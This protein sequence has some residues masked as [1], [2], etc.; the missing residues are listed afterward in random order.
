MP[1][2]ETLT[3]A[4]PAS[5]PGVVV[6]TNPATGEVV[7]QLPAASAADV[8]RAVARARAAQ[9]RWAAAS[10][11]ARARVVRRFHDLVLQRRDP[12][13]DTIQ[14]ESGRTRR[15]ALG[16]LLTVAGT[17]RYYLIHGPKHLRERRHR[18]AV[19]LATAA[20]LAYR[21]HGVVGLITP[22]NYPFLLAVADALPALLAGNAVVVK[23]PEVTPM[24]ALL[25]REMLIECGL[26]G[27]LFQV[28]VGPGR[29]LGPELVARVDYVGFTGSTETGRRVARAA[30]ERLIPF[31]LELGGKNPMIVLA[32]AP[33]DEAVSGLMTGA[34]TNT[35]Q[36]CIA[37][38]RVYVENRIYDA[39]V[40]QAAER[41]E[42]MALGFSLGWDVDMGSL[43]SAE[44]MAKVMSHVEDAIAKGAQ[45]LAGGRR[46]SDLGPN[47]VAPTLLA[48][49]TE[50][51]RLAR[52]ETFGPV[53]A[54]YRVRDEEE[55]IARAN[56]SEFGLN[57]A[58]WTGS[59]RRGWAVARQLAVGSAGVNS[60]LLVYHTFDVPMG[61]VK[62]SGLGRRHGAEGI[63]RYVQAQSLVA[64][65]ATRGGYEALALGINSERRAGL[66]AGA[67]RLMRRLPGLR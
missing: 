17:A 15:D 50:E 51:M 28:L 23:P 32:D 8:E 58:V 66:L 29:E 4:Q 42:K 55:A 24:S 31:S 39:F 10:F 30:A 52:E 21:P 3:Q 5:A 62:A 2:P 43:S 14:R 1:S 13:L 33:L 65:F 7:A 41:I 6:V 40:R 49:V 18:A 64:S 34:Y 44:Q 59:R 54:V 67:F 46:R 45:V 12:T 47:F 37:I 53:V 57:A 60:T 16:E 27:D 48:G 56:D 61:G 11:A 25:A 20:R 9:P 36:T 35:G 26:D 19:P 22:W 38:E 63:L